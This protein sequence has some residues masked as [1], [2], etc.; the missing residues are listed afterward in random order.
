MKGVKLALAAAVASVGVFGAVTAA[1][2]GAAAPE[3]WTVYCDTGGLFNTTIVVNSAKD[4]GTHV[5]SCLN[6]GGMPRVSVGYPWD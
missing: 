1:P 4:I 5:R 6:D 2:A 3:A